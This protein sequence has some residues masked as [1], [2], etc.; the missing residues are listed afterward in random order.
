[1]D[2]R[3]R[4]RVSG[5]TLIELLVVVAIIAILAAMLLP[6]LSMARERA[7]TA[8]CMNNMK[9]LILAWHMYLDDYK[10]ILPPVNDAVY[11][12]SGKLY[13]SE[14]GPCNYWWP[15]MM[16]DHLNMPELQPGYWA[17]IPVRYQKGILRCPSNRTAGGRLVNQLETHYGIPNEIV[18]GRN[19][20]D[21]MPY[22]KFS[23]IRYPSDQIV[24]VDAEGLNSGYGGNAA[25]WNNMYGYN[26]IALRHNGGRFSN[27]AFAD[28]R[29]ETRSFESLYV[30]GAWWFSKLWGRPNY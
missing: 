26:G 3:R 22:M 30:P 27:V 28:G 12:F 18:G 20:G 24:F 19:Y 13:G 11:R 6:A 4:S 23:E 9:Q 16:R 29:V 14:S 21:V 15:F 5:F 10:E 8:V 7:R 2:R 1:M 25:P 17:T